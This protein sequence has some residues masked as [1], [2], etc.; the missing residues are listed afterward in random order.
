MSFLCVAIYRASVSVSAMWSSVCGVDV[1]PWLIRH[2]DVEGEKK[3]GEVY[4]YENSR[5]FGKRDCVGYSRENGVIGIIVI[6]STLFQYTFQ[7]QN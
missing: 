2:V 6:S 7:E 4:H 3:R 5:T 1:F